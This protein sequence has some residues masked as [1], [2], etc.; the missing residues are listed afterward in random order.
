MDIRDTSA[1]PLLPAGGLRV[2]PL[3]GLG[4]IGRN[5][6]VLEYAG[7]LLI[8]DCGVL[9]PE[10]NQPGV[11]LVIPDF[12]ILADRWDHIEAV[13]LTHGHEDHIGGIPYL[14]GAGLRAPIVGSRLTL[15]FTRAKLNERPWLNA[16]FREVADRERVNFGP[17]DC[18]FLAVNH[19][20]P[21]AHAVAIRTGAGLLF[22]TGDFKADPLPLDGRLTDFPGFYAL[23]TE[24]V[25]LL[26]SDS[27]NAEV[28]GFITSEQE[29]GPVLSRVIGSAPGRVIAA[30]TSS[31]V[32]RIQ[33]VLIAAA[34]HERH[35]AII[36]RS[37]V[38]NMTIARELGHL[39]VPDGLI[40]DL[41][42]LNKF[43][44]Q[45]ALILCT[46]SQ[47][48]PMAALS[49][50]A[51]GEHPDIHLGSSDTVVLASSL[52]PGNET[53]VY[54]LL[55]KLAYLDVEVVTREHAAVHVSGHAARGELLNVLTAL[56]PSNFMPVH[57]EARHLRAHGKLAVLAGVPRNR[58]V[59]GR[60]GAV[61]DL[62][63]GVA[64]ITGHVQAGYTYIDG[65]DVG[66]V[67]EE[68]LKDRRI[69][70]DEG[71]ISAVV[72]VDSETGKV[73]TGPDI[74][75]RGFLDDERPLEDIREGVRADIEA[76]PNTG[77]PVDPV[78][79]QRV[80]KRSIGR[81]V[82]KI[83]RRRPMI[84]VLVIEI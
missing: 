15:A 62:V 31:H 37:M 13:L 33:Q 45:S 83:H 5:M 67:G 72:I 4:E 66:H 32:H 77:G 55:N 46:G 20:I 74:S 70:R 19:S 52:I 40:L 51:A 30:C 1:P 36:G 8:V 82:S 16:E 39:K 9:F 60:D 41:D 73:V 42:E 69:L 78:D 53:A 11:D 57:G 23:G 54:H 47:G 84:L 44:D 21:D 49:R 65:L 64:T 14:L 56:R 79:L 24:G 75:A 61:V 34:K 2:I 71:F 81:Q 63:D 28:E 50:M 12:T 35:V 17:F 80:V 27:T 10:E 22:H 48:E 6:T 7:R 38:R 18:Q 26:L 29:T 25:D 68:S 58:V 59:I 76:V 43:P 3:G